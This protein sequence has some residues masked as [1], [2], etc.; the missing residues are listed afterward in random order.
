M[1]TISTRYLTINH[2][3]LKLKEKRDWKKIKLTEAY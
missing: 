3:R 2:K 1:D